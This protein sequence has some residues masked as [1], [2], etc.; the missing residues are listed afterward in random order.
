[1]LWENNMRVDEI[2]FYKKL[3]E[4][5]KNYQPIF[6]TWSNSFYEKTSDFTHLVKVSLIKDETDVDDLHPG[7][8]GNYQIYELMMHLLNNTQKLKTINLLAK[9]II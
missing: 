4:L 2:N 7:V 3:N 8:F 9:P 6:V 1:M 5:L